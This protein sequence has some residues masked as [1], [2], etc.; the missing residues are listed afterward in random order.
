MFKVSTIKLIFY[1][2]ALYSKTQLI[3]PE[4]CIHT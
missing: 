1:E 3:L 4:K 2:K